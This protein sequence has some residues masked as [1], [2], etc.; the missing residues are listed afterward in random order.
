M[1]VVIAGG[2]GQIALLL[3]Q[4]LATRGDA[5]TALVRNPDHFADVSDAG[6]VPVLCD[7]ESADVDSV[8]AYLNGADAAVFAA[9]AGAGSG[10]ARKDT[11]DYGAAALF[12]S[13]A[14]ES[15]VRRFLQV[16]TVGIEAADSPSTDPEFAVYLRAKGLAEEDLKPRDLDWTILRPGP[17]VNDAPTGLVTI[18]APRLPR[19]SVTRADVAA[20]LAELLNAPGTIGKTLEL[21]NGETPVADAVRAVL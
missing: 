10:N 8:A 14:V 11:V 13:A 4:L 3:E 12:A 15:G 9:G 7:L 16:S 21:T 20:V 19:S 6:A 5:V 2:H 17:L 1:R 18:G